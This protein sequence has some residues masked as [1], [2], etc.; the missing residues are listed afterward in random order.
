MTDPSMPPS[1]PPFTTPSPS[2]RQTTTDLPTLLVTVVPIPVLVLLLIAQIIGTTGFPSNAPVE[3][4]MAIGVAIDL[5]AAGIALGVRAAVIAGRTRAPYAGPVGVS[6]LGVAGAVLAGLVL[7]AFVAFSLVSGIVNAID[8]SDQ[9]YMAWSAGMFYLG[10]PW[11]LGLF[12]SAAA[13]R[14][15]RGAVNSALSITA[16][17]VLLAVAAGTVAAAI[18]YGAGL[19]E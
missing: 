5:A 19:T 10:V 14:P 12:F 13:Y 17:V 9:R 2:K 6:K 11:V 16:I 15:G 8:G 3:Q 18:A 1:A 4:L 7:L